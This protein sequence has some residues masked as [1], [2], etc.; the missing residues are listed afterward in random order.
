MLAGFWMSRCF[1]AAARLGIA[2]LLADGPKTC[3]ELAKATQTHPATLYRVLRALASAAIFAET[4]AGCF[5]LTPRAN[6]LR[7]G[8]PGSVRHLAISILGDE[9]YAAWEHLLYSVRTG[10]SA[11]TH[12]FQLGVWDYYA[13]NPANARCFDRA[14]TEA[15]SLLHTT[16]LDSYDF[17]R[18]NEIVDVGGGQ[19]HLLARILKAYP[20][21]RGVLLD[22]PDVL[23]DADAYLQSVE[24][25]DR[26]CLAAGDFFDAVPDGADAYL[27]KWLLHDYDDARAAAILRNCRSAMYEGSRLL[28]VE[29]VIPPGNTPSFGKLTDVNMLVMTGGRERTEVEYRA[30]LDSSGF[31]LTRI[32][33]T[34]SPVSVI[35]GM[36]A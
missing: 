18:F 6:L 23:A 16:L 19:G 24:V 9:H 2:D 31:R 5:L 7:T 35:E 20:A 28:L 4:E 34:T 33:P 14:M 27:L 8:I 26:C 30:L 21:L 32:V 10:Q 3:D 1:Y 13:R 12:V 17:S 29:M 11:F 36:P 22:K 25:R 15:N